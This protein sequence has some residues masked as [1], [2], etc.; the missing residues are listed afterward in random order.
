VQAYEKEFAQ[1]CET[2]YCVAVSSGTDALRF[3]LMAAGI[4]SD[5][6]VVTRSSNK[7]TAQGHSSYG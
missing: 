1:F 6:E 7:S 4:G 3:A 2:R 5:G